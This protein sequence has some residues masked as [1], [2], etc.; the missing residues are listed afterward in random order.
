M[1][2]SFQSW[3]LQLRRTLGADVTHL[4]RHIRSQRALNADAVGPGVRRLQGRVIEVQVVAGTAKIGY[5][6]LRSLIPGGGP[7][8]DGSRNSTG[9]VL[10]RTDERV[11]RAV[12]VA[13]W[14]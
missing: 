4:D 12:V 13:A 10:A 8:L 9:Q 3:T 2:K 5:A 6:G 14:H 11:G 1:L 7:S